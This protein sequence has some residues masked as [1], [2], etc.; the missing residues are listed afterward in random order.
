MVVEWTGLSPDVLVHVDRSSAEPIGAQV[1]RELRTAIQTG[2]LSRNERLPSSRQLAEALGVSRGLVVDSY[3]QLEAEGYI[4]TRPGS[5][6]MVA[7]AGGDSGSADVADAVEAP[8]AMDFAYG[9][10]DLNKFPMRDWMWAL[11]EAA[12]SVP[13]AQFGYGQPQGA[14][15]LRRVLA[16]Y[17]NRVRGARTDSPNIVVCAGYAQGLSLVLTVLARRGATRIAV[18]DPGDR[19]NDRAI[20]RAGLEPVPIDVDELGIDV[21]GVIAA[22]VDAV[23]LTPAHQCP[24]GVALASSRRHQLLE[25]AAATGALI[26]EDD[27]DAEFRY[28]RQPIGSVQGLAAQHVAALGTVSKSLAPFL[29]LGW[30]V[31]PSDFVDDVVHEK[32]CAD[33]GSPGLDQLALASL[34]SSGRFDR[35]LRRMRAVYA[36]RRDALITAL[37]AHA[38]AASITGL[39]AGFHA[40]VTLPDGVSESDVVAAARQRSVGVYGMGDYRFSAG[41]T[42]PRLVLGFGNLTP[43]TITR[44]IERVG[45]LLR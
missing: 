3:Q 6:T 13:I 17:L 26:I 18:E 44:A 10:P 25:W 9:R 33:R 16:A 29:R 28:D 1:Q 14:P 22:G 24:T 11:A 5:G 35:H 39:A 32:L 34:I 42:P 40:V 2:R 31:C 45:D 38:P 7:I 19:E 8:L 36:E 43:S 4:T 27:Y 23:V 37:R 21:D 41:E 30:I 15:E 20:R 12:R